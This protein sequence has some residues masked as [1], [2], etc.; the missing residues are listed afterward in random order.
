M[1]NRKRKH[2]ADNSLLCP[3]KIGCHT[4]VRPFLLTRLNELRDR[5]VVHRLDFNV[6]FRCADLQ[7]LHDVVEDLL[8]VASPHFNIHVPAFEFAKIKYVAEVKKK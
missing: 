8:V 1:H 3:S 4:S 5:R 6:P 2:E 7:T